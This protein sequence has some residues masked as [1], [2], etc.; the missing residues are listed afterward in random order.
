[1]ELW[2]FPFSTINEQTIRMPKG[3]IVLAVQTE[4]GVP[5]MWAL[6]NPAAEKENRRFSIRETENN[7]DN[8]GKYLGTYQLHN[9]TRTFH[10]FDSI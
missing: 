6:V 2:K 5:C 9:N 10:L 8:L 1:M 4:Q 3:A 7:A